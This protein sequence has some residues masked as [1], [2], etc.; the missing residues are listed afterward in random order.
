MSD[1]SVILTLHCSIVT[2]EIVKFLVDGTKQ[3]LASYSPVPNKRNAWNKS[4]GV[5]AMP[6]LISVMHGIR[7]MVYQP[8]KI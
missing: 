7:V 2:Q 4:N 5:P 1:Y 6:K 8:C 3:L